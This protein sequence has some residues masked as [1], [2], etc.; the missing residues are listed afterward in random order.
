MS[1]QALSTGQEKI[2]VKLPAELTKRL[3]RHVPAR[4]RDAF[5]AHAVTEQLDIEEQAQALEETVGAW[6]D[7]DYPE[8]ATGA[9]VDTWLEKLRGSWSLRIST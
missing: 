1:T 8:L 7:A 2:T 4:E 6:K 9:D 3:R 5:I